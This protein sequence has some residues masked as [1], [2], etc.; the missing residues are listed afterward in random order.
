MKF[1]DAKEASRT[2]NG[3]VSKQTGHLISSIVKENLINPDVKL[4]L[5]SAV[6]FKGMW[7]NPFTGNRNNV[8]CFY[9]EDNQCV[10]SRMM[11]ETSH[12][13]FGYISKLDAQAVKL[14]YK[15]GYISGPKVRI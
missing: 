6:Y 3:W 2:I 9:T 15:V 12:Y 13:E 7:S 4:M 10:K 8:R 11:T 14:P 1:E 5:M